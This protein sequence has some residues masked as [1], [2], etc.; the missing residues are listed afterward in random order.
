MD[1]SYIYWSE[2]VF[3]LTDRKMRFTYN[4]Y[5][6]AIDTLPTNADLALWYEGQVSA[7]CKLEWLP[8]S[9]P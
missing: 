5:N 2:A 4:A 6:A 7:Q 1:L 3:S 9:D 8:L